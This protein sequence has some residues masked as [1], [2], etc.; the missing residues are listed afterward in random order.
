MVHND[1]E[2]NKKHSAVT[3]DSSQKNGNTTKENVPIEEQAQVNKE[4]ST[5]EDSKQEKLTKPRVRLIPIW[6]RLILV[7]FLFVACLAMGLA[8]GY[9]VIGDGNMMDVFDKETWTHIIDLVK[10]DIK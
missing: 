5:R 2:A 4:A 1:I 6:L 8:V 3:S 10:K 9:G 7:L